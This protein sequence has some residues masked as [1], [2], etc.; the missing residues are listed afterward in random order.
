MARN[1]NGGT[2]RIAYSGGFSAVP[3]G[4][5]ASFHMRFRTTQATTNVQL[6]AKWGSSSRGGFGLLLNNTANK[7]SLIGYSPTTQRVLVATATSVNDGNW[8]TVTALMD[9]NSGGNNSI[10]LDGNLDAQQNASGG[11]QIDQNAFLQLGDSFDTFWPSYVGDVAEVAFWYNVTLTAA[12]IASLAK[13]FSARL[14]RPT[15]LECYA[16]MVRDHQSRLENTIAASGFSGTT[17]VDHPRVI[18]GCA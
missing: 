8:H 13:G 10:Y 1:F 15:A 18:G 7:L 3:S 2:D 9:T 17:V 11:W 14:I 5:K 12:E 4:E 6:A 16:P